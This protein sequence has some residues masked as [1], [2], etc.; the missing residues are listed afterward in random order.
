MTAPRGRGG[1]RNNRGGRGGRGGRPQCTYCKRMGHT[2]KNCYSLHGFPNKVAHASKS[3]KSE[4]KFS[5]EEYQEYLK[6]KYEKSSNQA[7]SSSVPDVSTTCISQSVKVQAL[8]YLT[9]V[10]LIIS[11]VT[12]RLFHSFLFQKL[13]TLLV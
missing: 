11:L 3:E 9:Q 5:D 8:E 7:Q 13:L 2:Q 10:P 12:N 6:L 4:S 1:S